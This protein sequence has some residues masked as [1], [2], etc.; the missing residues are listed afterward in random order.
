MTLFFRSE[1]GKFA[2]RLGAAQVEALLGKCRSAGAFE[3]GGIVAGCY[4]H[5][6]SVAEVTEVSGPPADSRAGRTWFARGVR[7]AGEWLGKLWK[8]KQ[9]Y[10]GEWHFHPSAAPDPSE[11]DIDQMREIASSSGYHCP[12]PL[13]LI[14]G[15]D[16]ARGY[17]YRAFVSP[18]DGLHKELFA[19]DDPF[20]AS[21]ALPSV[22]TAG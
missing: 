3:T 18:R 15:G 14:V 16:S 7:G 8:K 10:L 9:Y 13:M 12:E 11:T 5:N 20:V 22:D 21:S 2:L 4:T 17:R 1:D 6:L 19:C